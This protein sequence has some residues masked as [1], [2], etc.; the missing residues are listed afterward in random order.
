MFFIILWSLS[1]Y[2]LYLIICLSTK[3]FFIFAKKIVVTRVM[4]KLELTDTVEAMT[5]K[6]VLMM[7]LT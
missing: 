1:G 2:W 6:L 4:K 3:Y 7:I 5:D